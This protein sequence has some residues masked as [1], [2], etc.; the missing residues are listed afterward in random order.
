MTVGTPGSPAPP[1]RR[2]SAAHLRKSLSE[3]K[4]RSQSIAE[5]PDVATSPAQRKAVT[6]A[7]EHNFSLFKQ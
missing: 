5:T 2:S 4:Q 1:G 6:S 3:L 7:G